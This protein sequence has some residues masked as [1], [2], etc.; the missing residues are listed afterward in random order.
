[1]LPLDSFLFFSWLHFHTLN[2]S[3]TN[4]LWCICQT[5]WL[6]THNV[7]LSPVCTTY[8]RRWINVGDMGCVYWDLMSGIS[9]YALS[10][11]RQIY[12][13]LQ[14]QEP[15]AWQQV[16]EWLLGTSAADLS[17]VSCHCVWCFVRRWSK[18]RWYSASILQGSLTTLRLANNMTERGGQS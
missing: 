9:E 10:H 2:I 11:S 3:S 12:S 13:W 18:S 5:S 7:L 4:F 6:L 8:G 17:S 1:M 15:H 16:I 14:L